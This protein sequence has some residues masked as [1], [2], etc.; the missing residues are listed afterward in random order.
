MC[1]RDSY[2]NVN[3]VLTSLGSGINPT[4]SSL[5]LAITEITNTDANLNINQIGT[6]A[7]VNLSDNINIAGD[8]TL[9][10][11]SGISGEV[12][13]SQGSLPPIWGPMIAQPQILKN[14]AAGTLQYG[15]QSGTSIVLFAQTYTNFTVGKTSIFN[16]NVNF[17]VSAIAVSTFNISL[18]VDS[19][20]QTITSYFDT[21]GSTS[22]NLTYVY[23]AT[24]TAQ[25]VILSGEQ[26]TLAP[27]NTVTFSLQPYYY[28]TYQIMEIQ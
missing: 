1:I 28:I 20:T 7:T 14:I 24:N 22:R 27:I 15:V 4:W 3:E 9:N 5:A 17:N 18:D 8:L 13:I 26:S 2:G 21:S 19:T 23:L 11:Q 12:I 6:I 16:F 25:T 10:S